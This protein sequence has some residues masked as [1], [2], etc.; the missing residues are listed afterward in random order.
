MPE[1]P[2]ALLSF[3]C[4][5]IGTFLAIDRWCGRR[6]FP[7]GCCSTT[8]C[9]GERPSRRTWAASS[10][11]ASH[12]VDHLVGGRL[13]LAEQLPKLTVANERCSG[14]PRSDQP[15]A[16]GKKHLICVTPC[17]FM[18]GHTTARPN[19]FGWVTTAIFGNDYPFAL[20]PHPVVA[21]L[22][23]PVYVFD[24]ATIGKRTAKSSAAAELVDHA[25]SGSFA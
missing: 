6:C 10:A 7:A 9:P 11:V 3:R 14:R 12:H 22:S 25:C 2:R 5:L 13:E 20:Q 23:V 16:P 15:C 8:A 1:P 24:R 18:Y 21:V 4:F 17:V 19:L